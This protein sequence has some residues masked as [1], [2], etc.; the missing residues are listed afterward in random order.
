M[1]I[2]AFGV[3]NA[4]RSDE[5]VDKPNSLE[6]FPNLVLGNQSI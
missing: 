6:V 1:I 3:I 2:L 4:G 5:P